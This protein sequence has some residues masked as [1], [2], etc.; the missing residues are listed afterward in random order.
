MLHRNSA[1]ECGSMVS[2]RIAS[3]W[4]YFVRHACAQP[5]KKRCSP[6]RPSMTGAG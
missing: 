3:A 6:V 2:R 5:R 4:R 1:G